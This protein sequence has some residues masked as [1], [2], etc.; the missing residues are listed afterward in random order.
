MILPNI[1]RV[2]TKGS[3][4]KVALEER[5]EI[6]VFANPSRNP[7]A[8]RTNFVLNPTDDKAMVAKGLTSRKDRKRVRVNRQGVIGELARIDADQASRRTSPVASLVVVKRR[9]GEVRLIMFH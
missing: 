2:S 5:R 7:S 1:N 4:N 3:I 6:R 8:R 9:S